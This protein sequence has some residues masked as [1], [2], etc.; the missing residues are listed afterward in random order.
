M[1]KFNTRKKNN[2]QNRMY[3]EPIEE[4]Y[5]TNNSFVRFKPRKNVDTLES[6]HTS[7]LKKS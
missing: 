3:S 7:L 4:N 6:F 5:E 1:R 2:F